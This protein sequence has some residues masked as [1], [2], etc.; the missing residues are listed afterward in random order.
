MSNTRDFPR[1][2]RSSRTL[3]RNSLTKSS[4]EAPPATVINITSSTGAP[5]RKAKKR[6][7]TSQ[8]AQTQTQ[9]QQ[10]NEQ[11]A[12]KS[13]TKVFNFERSNLSKSSH[14][15]LETLSSVEHYNLMQFLNKMRMAKLPNNRSTSTPALELSD[16][17]PPSLEIDFTSPSSSPSIGP[18]QSPMPVMLSPIYHSDASSLSS[19]EEDLFSSQLSG[20]SSSTDAFNNNLLGLP[21]SHVQSGLF[22]SPRNRKTLFPDLFVLNQIYNRVKSA[23]EEERPDFSNIVFACGQHLLNTTGSLFRMLIKLGARSEN[24]FVIGKSY[25]NSAAVI[26]GLK[27]QLDIQNVYEGTPRDE[28]GNFAEVYSH[29]VHDMWRD[30]EVHIDRARTNNKPIKDVIVLDDGGH[31]LKEMTSKIRATCKCIGI[32]QTSSGIG[33]AKRS[34]FPVIQVASS[35]IKNWCEPPMVS[36]RVA[37]KVKEKITE[38]LGSNPNLLSQVKYGIVGFG[39]IGK[40]VLEE[41]RTLPSFKSIIIFD[42]NPLTNQEAKLR[43][44]DYPNVKVVDSIDSLFIPASTLR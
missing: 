20:S 25:S 16:S 9:T 27:T 8:T 5:T 34:P 22:P 2:T 42:N 44:A 10:T 11:P 31:V 40:A 38:I 30:I 29:D 6:N 36:E 19:P 33:S 35:A 1:D 28:W 15:I 3:R 37:L 4:Q 17:E 39:H 13:K 12:K 26:T 32:E 24:I 41:L 21:V 7:H 43:C 18:M 23:P 14:S